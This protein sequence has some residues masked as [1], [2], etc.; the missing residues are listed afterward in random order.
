MLYQSSVTMGDLVTW[1]SGKA[2]I[3]NTKQYSWPR[4]RYFKF[5]FVFLTD[6]D[7]TIARHHLNLKLSTNV[8]GLTAIDEFN[9]R[10]PVVHAIIGSISTMLNSAFTPLNRLL[11]DCLLY[12]GWRVA[13]NG[14]TTCRSGAGEELSNRVYT[15]KAQGSVTLCFPLTILEYPCQVFISLNL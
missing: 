9:F 13:M 6:G 3:P 2:D 7:S 12:S 11:H 8:R 10:V 1:H 4:R 14:Q 15:Y 5:K